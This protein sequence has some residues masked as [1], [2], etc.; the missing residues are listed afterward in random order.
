MYLRVGLCGG[1]RLTLGDAPLVPSTL[2][3]EAGSLS[4]SHWPGTHSTGRLVWFSSQP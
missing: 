2:L 3:F 4:L 1:L